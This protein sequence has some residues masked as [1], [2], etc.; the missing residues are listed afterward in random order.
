MGAKSDKCCCDDCVGHCIN[1][2]SIFTQCSVCQE[3]P[4]R[5]NAGLIGGNKPVFSCCPDLHFQP[6]LGL[7]TGDPTSMSCAWKSAVVNCTDGT[8]AQWTLT[9]TSQAIGG[10]VLQVD[11][12]DGRR[13]VWT[14]IQRW[15]CLCRNLMARDRASDIGN[16]DPCNPPEEVCLLP[17]DPCCS[18][19]HQPL[20]RTL[21]ATLSDAGNCACITGTVIVLSWNPTLGM[22]IG[23]GPYGTCVGATFTIRVACSRS[24]ADVTDWNGD[25]QWTGG[26]A[27]CP[28]TGRLPIGT[29][30]IGGF[31]ISNCDPLHLQFGITQ[32]GNTCCGFIFGSAEVRVDIT[33]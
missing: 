14:N 10:V 24:I 9:I 3:S 22:W 8:T 33:E 20:P 30:I 1:I 21:Y 2:G 16:V 26:N 5:W 32:T 13:V 4:L 28:D 12:S 23:S 6:T 19:R 29:G 7:L 31:N 25:V 17:I 27:F 11:W 18:T 15:Q